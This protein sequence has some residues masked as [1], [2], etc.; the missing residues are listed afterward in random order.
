VQGRT[1]RAH[2]LSCACLSASAWL[3]TPFNGALTLKRGEFRSGLRHRPGLSML[4]PNAPAV[5][6]TSGATLRP[7]N[8]NHSMRCPPLVAQTTLHHDILKGILRRVVHRA[9]ISPRATPP[10]PPRPRRPGRESLPMALP[11]A[12]RPVA[13]S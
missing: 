6:C 12:Q 5:Q 2:L 11:S 3:D 7:C 9:G 10:P 1:A 13:T 4:P 8:G